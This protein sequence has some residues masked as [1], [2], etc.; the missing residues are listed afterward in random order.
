MIRRNLPVCLLLVLHAA[1]LIHSAWKKSAT[2]DELGHLAAGLYSLETL[3]FRLNRVAPPL[4]NLVCALPVY[5]LGE[6]RLTYDHQSWR[7]G[8]WNG[9]NQRFIEANPDTF[10]RHLMLGR[11]GAMALSVS[12][13][14]LAYRFALWL[15]G[16]VPALGVLAVTV[17]E[18]NL[19]AHGRL[20]TTDIAPALMFTATAC[21]LIFYLRKPT[22]RALAATGVLFGLTWYSKHSAP[23]L[24]P[25]FGLILLLAPFVDPRWKRVFLPRILRRYP[26]HWRPLI[27]AAGATGLIVSI[28][29]LAIWAGYGFETGD[30]TRIEREPM[31][32]FLWTSLSFYL[33]VWYNLTGHFDS[34]DPTDASNPIWAWIRDYCPA[35]SHWE[36]FLANRHHAETGHIS[37][38][39]GSNSY[40][41][42]DW[43]YPV[44]YLTKTPLPLMI[45]QLAGI[46]VLLKKR[47]AI[48]PSVLLVAIVIPTVYWLVLVFL[49]NANLGYRHLLPVVPL[50]IVV[51]VGAFF[52]WTRAAFNQ[53]RRGAAILAG[54][55]GV[56]YAADV[57]QVHPHYLSYFNSLAGG[58][59]QG[60]FYVVDSNLDWGQDLIY[61]KEYIDQHLS[62]PPYLYYFGPEEYPDAYGVRY[63]NIST[64]K[65]LSPGQYVISATALY[66]FGVQR[67][68]WLRPLL[69]RE[70][71]AFITPAVLVYRVE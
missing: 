59:H 69:E 61:I 47:S 26:P 29:C 46:V 54:L 9:I 23:I 52:G 10:H 67:Y 66:Q 35:Y 65:E 11:T 41:G 45:L 48:P 25:S 49:N 16:Y 21:S 5:W 28:G 56:W 33:Q 31:S 6:Y 42:S 37:Y 60:R 40:F 18:P 71:D 70:P 32:S 8:I 27:F 38:L 39:L 13:C 36:G 44:V 15:W 22:W 1:L 19:L 63:R 7:N 64:L 17:L 3:D 4:Q 58:P 43:Y 53:G 30:S 34:F 20:T 50:T 12:L 24:I 57:L 55:L 62:E 68:P 14:Y 2:V 51:P